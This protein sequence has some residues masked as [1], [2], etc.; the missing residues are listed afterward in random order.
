[1]A[2]TTSGSVNEMVNNYTTSDMTTTMSSNVSGYTGTK[3][4][5]EGFDNTD[6]VM[7]LYVVNNTKEYQKIHNVAPN[8]SLSVY[9]QLIRGT[10]SFSPERLKELDQ[11]Y[12]GYTH[13]FVLRMPPV[14]TVPAKGQQITSFDNP[15]TAVEYENLAQT[16]AKNLKLL[17]EM[18]STSYSG[19]PELTLNTA[20]VNVGWGDRAYSVPTFS[21]YGSKDF[22]IRCLEL[23]TNPLRRAVEY[24][25]NGMADVASKTT[26]MNG[27]LDKKDGASVAD[28][29]LLAPTLT[30]F[31]WTIMVVQTDNTLK[32]IQDISVWSNAIIRSIDRSDLDWENGTI[33]IV[34]PR[35]INFTGMYLSMTRNKIFNAIAAQLLKRRLKYYVRYEDMDGGWLADSAY[36]NWNNETGASIPAWYPSPPETG[37]TGTAAVR[38]R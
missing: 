15:S 13:V 7:P 32:N 29:K 27:A 18:G 9:S 6:T 8:P 37:V 38:T 26:H 21:E 12:T 36:S 31:T 35:D 20:D 1:M 3:A 17:I 16:H 33:D 11:S 2:E 23:R 28:A 30:N 14:L 19:T 4:S 10:M 5:Y 24:Y 34:Q 25:I 22:T